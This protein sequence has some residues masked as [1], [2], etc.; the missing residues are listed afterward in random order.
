L[1]PPPAGWRIS[2]SEPAIEL[3]YGTYHGFGFRTWRPNART[4]TGR[5]RTVTLPHWFIMLCFAT[6]PAVATYRWVRSR[7]NRQERDFKCP[8][9]GYDLRATPD[10]CPECGTVV[11]WK[12][13]A[14]SAD[15]K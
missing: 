4:E 12:G 5:L 2:G 7:P 8:K 10:R 13:K 1:L 3:S 15:S 14:A 6:L 9:C 11:A